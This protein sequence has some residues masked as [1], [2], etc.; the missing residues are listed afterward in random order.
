[1]YRTCSLSP[2]QLPHL[3]MCSPQQ[4]VLEK[5]QLTDW[6]TDGRTDWGQK[7]DPVSEGMMVTWCWQLPIWDFKQ[8]GDSSTNSPLLCAK[9]SKNAKNGPSNGSNQLS[10]CLPKR[11]QQTVWEWSNSKPN[12]HPS[13]VWKTVPW[14][15]QLME[16]TLSRDNVS[17]VDI[18]IS[19]T[20]TTGTTT[21]NVKERVCPPE[22]HLLTIVLQSCLINCRLYPCSTPYNRYQSRDEW[23]TGDFL[24]FFLH[25]VLRTRLFFLS[26]S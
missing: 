8:S 14:G 10:Y 22:Y 1:M 20:T 13:N 12:H 4:N 18:Y 21:C 5:G 11:K 3:S 24:F 19:I 7:S 9:E 15:K 26:P 16:A 25:S 2:C 17:M 6:R 23:M